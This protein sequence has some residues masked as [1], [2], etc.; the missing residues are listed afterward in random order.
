MTTSSDLL[1]FCHVFWFKNKFSK[2]ELQNFKN[3]EMKLS[4]T[5]LGAIAV[6]QADDHPG[7]F[8]TS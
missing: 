4:S 1:T 5:F 3:S 6:A 7:N 2:P 8:E